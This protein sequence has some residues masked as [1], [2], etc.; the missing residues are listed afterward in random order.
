MKGPR[1]R[2]RL[3]RQSVLDWGTCSRGIPVYGTSS[4]RRIHLTKTLTRR[5]RSVCVLLYACIK[6]LLLPTQNCCGNLVD[7]Y[8]HESS[9]PSA[10]AASPETQ[11][12]V[13]PFWSFSRFVARFW[14]L[15]YSC[16]TSELNLVA[17]VKSLSGIFTNNFGWV[18]AAWAAVSM[19]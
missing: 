2:D 14:L 11:E 12:E 5:W 16:L 4:P 1:F 6:V 3:W 7:A 17:Y 8:V 13:K 18:M 15:N 19:N 10:P 9:N